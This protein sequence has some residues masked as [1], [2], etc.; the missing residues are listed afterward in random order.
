M[1]ADPEIFGENDSS[2]EKA[3]KMSREIKRE[4]NDTS[5]GPRVSQKCV[6]FCTFLQSF[7][8]RA[9]RILR[10][11]MRAERRNNKQMNA[12]EQNILKSRFFGRR[13]KDVYCLVVSEV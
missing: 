4:R 1:Y 9:V 6:S 8:V 2:K 7:F 13:Q 5:G 11:V 12:G 3:R 10:R